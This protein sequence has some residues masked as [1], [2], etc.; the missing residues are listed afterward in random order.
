MTNPAQ[1]KLELADRME[2]TAAGYYSV[3]FSADERLL[4][5]SVLRD[6]AAAPVQG[7]G[8]PVAWREVETVRLID[9]L[10]SQE[11]DDVTILCDNPDFNGQPN[12]AVLCNGDWTEYN[13]QRFVGD[14]VL[15]ALSAAA[16]DY[17]LKKPRE[18]IAESNGHHWIE[19]FN[20][21]CCRDCGIVRRADD[22]NKPCKGVVSVGPRARPVS[23]QEG[24]REANLKDAEEF[25]KGAFGP[26]V[27]DVSQY[28]EIVAE[29]LDRV[30]TRTLTAFPKQEAISKWRSLKDA[31]P[32]PEYQAF[33]VG[34]SKGGRND[35]VFRWP[36]PKTGRIAFWC[37]A[38]HDNY[39]LEN[40]TPDVW[41]PGPPP[42]PGSDVEKFKQ[43]KLP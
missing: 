16:T 1:T 38:R 23:A 6:A 30:T 3:G 21:V 26:F 20:L 24:V 17:N 4:V 10:R 40:Y 28:V 11:G 5:I 27:S 31:P 36:H 39:V 12:C 42:I 18:V 32:G 41:H 43:G 19:R 7:A 29:F 22:K 13:D 35:Y 33:F 9:L 25:C 14:T 15:D 8:E 2:A 34:H 37:R